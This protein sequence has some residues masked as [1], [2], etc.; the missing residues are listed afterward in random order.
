MHETCPGSQL[1]FCFRPNPPAARIAVSKSRGLL[2][3]ASRWAGN[4]C[5]SAM[6]LVLLAS[7]ILSADD[8]LSRAFRAADADKNG[9]A[10][11]TE[12][13]IGGLQ[14]TVATR[15]FAMCDHN[16][17]GVLSL[18]EF[19]AFRYIEQP[20]KRGDF[21]DPM[22]RLV[23]H[24]VAAMDR[25]FEDWDGKPDQQIPVNDFLSAFLNMLGPQT[26]TPSRQEADPDS[27]RMVSRPEARRFIEIQLGLRTAD[28]VVLRIN[29]GRVVDLNRFRVVDSNQNGSLDR[30]EFV[31]PGEAHRNA[32]F[33][34]L[35]SDQSG[36]LTLAEWASSSEGLADPLLRFRML[37]SNLD[38]RLDSDE[39][40]TGLPAEQKHFD[41]IP[42]FDLDEDGTLDLAEFRFAIP[43][44][45]LLGW[46]R[47]L[48]DRDSDQHISFA[49][50]S[51]S[52]TLQFPL[53]RLVYFERL[54]RNG[55]ELLGKDELTFRARLPNEL[56]VVNSDGSGWRPLLRFRGYPALGS[57]AVSPDGKWIAFDAHRV[58]P[59]TGS[60][61]F[62]VGIDGGVPL[63]VCA[64]AMPSWSPSGDRFAFSRAGVRLVTAEGKDERVFRRNGWG[65]QWSPDGK[66][67]ALTEAA[68]LR[69]YDVDE[70]TTRTIFNGNAH[71]YNR[72]YWNMA[73]SPDGQRICF[74][75]SKASGSEEVLTVKTSGGDPEFT[76][77]HSSLRYVV[78]DFAWHP[79]EGRVLFSTY[80]PERECRQVYEFDPDRED[81]P[82]LFPGQDPTRN[83]TD[84]SWT[85]DG[86]Q[87]VVTSGDY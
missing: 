80:C 32:E 85:P 55:D 25:S 26:M 3:T 60:E 17:D 70:K 7:T 52:N 8:D 29:D 54:D 79:E 61:I 19:R 9:V 41:L 13:G 59:R 84:M 82:R 77:H 53:L 83:V 31:A 71:G 72:V 21:P 68:D 65:A 20:K 58:Q 38:A 36:D 86:T 56:F 34:K 33:D 69:I 39:L 49:E 40:T 5:A 14:P 63:Q 76:V 4:R 27:D 74:K 10:S 66:S 62:V 81:P 46:H 24:T 67:I 37:D 51:F 78:A 30:R 75:A 6:A 28:D 11:R 12:L 87:L 43:A 45:P 15:D 64:G 47:I 2:S 42:A 73:W 22:R 48:Q 35:D 18:A 16:G 50:F 23:D 1:W 44:N 57:P